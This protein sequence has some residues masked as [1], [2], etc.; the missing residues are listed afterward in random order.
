MNTKLAVAL[1]LLLSFTAG[2]CV[3]E[4]RGNE[5]V[6]VAHLEKEFSA[7]SLAYKDGD[8]GECEYYAKRDM[9]ITV[10]ELKVRDKQ[11]H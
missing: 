2:A 3:I 5:F 4:K 11:L 1:L 9:L 8:I 7:L 10:W 6:G